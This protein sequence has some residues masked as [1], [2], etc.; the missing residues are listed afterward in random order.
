ME[1]SSCRC[2][3]G[4]GITVLGV[5]RNIVIPEGDYGRKESRLL[6]VLLSASVRYKV[7]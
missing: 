1:E 7:P 6:G 2:N 3:A 4:G 5:A